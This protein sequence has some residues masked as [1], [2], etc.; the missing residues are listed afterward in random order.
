MSQSDVF[1]R[2]LIASGRNSCGDYRRLLE[3]YGNR[4]FYSMFHYQPSIYTQYIEGGLKPQIPYFGRLGFLEELNQ[5][6]RGAA[7][8]DE[9]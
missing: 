4:G 2:V 9:P 5:R 6:N 3:Y 8:K 7:K 1:A